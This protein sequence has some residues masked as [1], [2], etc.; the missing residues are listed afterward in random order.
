[1]GLS[2]SIGR[3]VFVFGKQPDRRGMFSR[4]RFLDRQHLIN[5][6]ATEAEP[7]ID[8]WRDSY[9]FVASRSRPVCDR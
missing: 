8:F 5:E 2:V 4:M 3:S 6:V 9:A 7:W 1:M